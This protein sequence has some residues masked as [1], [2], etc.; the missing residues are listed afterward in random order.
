M[1]KLWIENIDNPAKVFCVDSPNENFTDESNNMISWD[2]A[3]YIMDWSRR[4][5]MISPL[6]YIKA[7][8]NL[9]N[10]NSLSLD[11][12][13]IGA[14]YFLV[15]YS[16]RVTN[17]IVTEIEDK[18]NW[19][20]LLK[21][22]KQSRISC[23]EAMRLH[24]G[25]YVRTGGLSLQLTQQFFKDVYSLLILFT[26]SNLPDFKLWLINEI[27]SNYENN[28]FA[29]KSYF[30]SSLRDELMLIYNGDY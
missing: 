23:I 30:S 10:Y 4:R 21:E 1:K 25:D 29:Q 26:E 6:F 11:E 15:P 3:I 13:I 27:G 17:N 12:K 9:S 14:K 20:N 22:T 8:Y 28:G 19:I 2:K 5:D 24:A 18:L 7:N 16:L